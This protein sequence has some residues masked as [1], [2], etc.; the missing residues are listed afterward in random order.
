MSNSRCME[1]DQP[2]SLAQTGPESFARKIL[3]AVTSFFDLI[4]IW[5]ERAAERAHL[6]TLDD[7]LLRDMGLSRADVDQESTLPFWRS[8]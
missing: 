4:L 6:A 2:L 3:R 7:R 5:Q 8:R 1:L